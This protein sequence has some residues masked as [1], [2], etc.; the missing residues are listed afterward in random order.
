MIPHSVRIGFAGDIFVAGYAST[1]SRGR[2]VLVRTPRGVELGEILGPMT[3]HADWR[4][5]RLQIVRPTTTNDELLLER[6]ER[7]KVRAVQECQQVLSES[8]SSAML[9]DVDQLFDGQTLILHFC[10]PPDSL[11]QDLTDQIVRRYEEEVRSIP[12]ADLLEKGCGDH[13][14]TEEASGCGGGCS[15]CSLAKQCAVAAR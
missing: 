9:L 1:L 13:C 12:L 6:L 15:S 5:S 4:P 8:A 14:G 3:D 7:F 11:G 10:G 2:R